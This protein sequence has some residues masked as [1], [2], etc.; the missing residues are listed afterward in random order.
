VSKITRWNR[1]VEGAYRKSENANAR[2]RALTSQLSREIIAKSSCKRLR[3]IQRK[4]DSARRRQSSAWNAYIAM[5][6]KR[7]IIWL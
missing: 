5:K 6:G 2:V 1:R 7:P 4:L 3:S